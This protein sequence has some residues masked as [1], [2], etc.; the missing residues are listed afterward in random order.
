MA[1]KQ[2][3]DPSL[4]IAIISAALMVL[5]NATEQFGKIAQFS[6]GHFQDC[7]EAMNEKWGRML[8]KST[9]H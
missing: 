5:M 8:D 7:F 6:G 4:V 9:E 2:A 1:Y 3:N